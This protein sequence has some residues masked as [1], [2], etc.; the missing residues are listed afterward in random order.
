MDKESTSQFFRDFKVTKS[1]RPAPQTG[2]GKDVDHLISIVPEE[3]RP[4]DPA[5]RSFGKDLVPG[6]ENADP[7]GRVP[8]GSLLGMNNKL[9]PGPFRL[10][11]PQPHRRE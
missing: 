3:M 6:P 1:S 9:H 5:R 8:F 10:V 2:K 7:A 4:E 11:F